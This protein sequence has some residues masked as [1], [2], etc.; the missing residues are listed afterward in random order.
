MMEKQSVTNSISFSCFP[1]FGREKGGRQGN[2][3][4]VVRTLGAPGCPGAGE[5]PSMPC[6]R[7]SSRLAPPLLV[8]GRGK[9]CAHLSGAGPSRLPL[10]T[11]PFTAP[12]ERRAAQPQLAQVL[13]ACGERQGRRVDRGR[14]G[15]SEAE[16]AKDDGVRAPTRVWAGSP[17]CLPSAPNPSRVG[18]E[19]GR[20]GV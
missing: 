9:V 13:R 5:G 10:S 15:I 19:M 6:G 8:P 1:E 12:P 16:T 20:E 4:S 3:L 14:A 17:P 7:V 2:G 18:D 11:R